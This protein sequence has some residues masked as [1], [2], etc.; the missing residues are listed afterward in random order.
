MPRLLFLAASLSTSVDQRTN[1]LS[2]FHLVEQFN[3][4]RFPAVL[5]YFEVVCLWQRESGDDI[6]KFEQRVRMLSPGGVDEVANFQIEFPMERMR[7]RAIVGF[8]GIKVEEPGFYEIEVCV[9][10]KATD[11]WDDPKGTYYIQVS[12]P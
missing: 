9:R 3:P 4:D 2:L 6:H 10:R 5:P 1:Q 11:Q 8:A 7:H 12:T